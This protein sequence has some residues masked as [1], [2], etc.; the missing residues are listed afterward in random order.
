MENN[1]SFQKKLSKIDLPFWKENL[2][3]EKERLKGLLDFSNGVEH[4][5]TLDAKRNIK[6]YEDK[7]KEIEEF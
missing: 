1:S 2:E 6:R 4:S 5:A 3:R 7:I